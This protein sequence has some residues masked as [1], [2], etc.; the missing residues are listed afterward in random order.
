MR[1][2]RDEDRQIRLTD[3]RF[4]NA[5][6]AEVRTGLLGYIS[7]TV[8][9]TLRLDGLTIRRTADGRRTLSF[10]ARR[11]ATGRQHYFVRPLDDRA[12]REIEHQVFQA[13]GIDVEA[14][15]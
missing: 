9:G 8:N 10:P 14:T 5:T 12:R 11:D 13:L 15:R 6:P 7:V 1:T 3:L 4:T 2:G